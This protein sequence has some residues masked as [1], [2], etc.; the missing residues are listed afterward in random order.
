MKYLKIRIILFLFVFSVSLQSSSDGIEK[1]LNEV[2]SVASP[3]G[4]EHSMVLT[5][6]KLLPADSSFETDSLGSL[7]L[8]FGDGGD[9]LAV[10]TGIDEIGYIVSGFDSQGYLNEAQARGI[11]ILDPVTPLARNIFTFLY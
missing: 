2:F 3:T 4:Y 8:D 9:H 11:E 5:I 7:Y 10:L 6:K 1:T